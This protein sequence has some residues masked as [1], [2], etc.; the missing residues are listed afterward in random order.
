[1]TATPT[2][3]SLHTFYQRVRSRS[4][5]LIAPLSGEDC[6]LQS[7][8]DASPQKWHLAHTSWFWETFVLMPGLPG[9][10]PFDPAFAYLF[11]S[12]YNTVGEQYPR[13]LRGLLSRPDLNTVL[14]YREHVDAGMAR[15]FAGNP[16]AVADKQALIR[17]GLNHEQQHQ[18][19]QLTDVKHLLSLNPLA[20]AYGEAL[21]RP[22]VAHASLDWQ[23]LGGHAAAI[24]HEDGGFAFDNEM[25]AHTQWLAPY[26]IANR[27]VTNGEYLRF[28][29]AGGYR[30]PEFWLA[31]G[32]DHV[33]A[34][35]WAA[36]I[37]WRQ[38]DGQWLRF[39]LDG[40][41]PLA[42]DEPVA[43]LSLY[44]A[45]AYARFAGARLPTEFEWE[46]AA[47]HAGARASGL[48]D[49]AWQWTSSS[50]AAYPGFEPSAGAIGEYNGKFMVNQ[51]VLRGGS[52]LTPTGHTRFTYR[53][54]FPAATRWQ[55]TGVRLARSVR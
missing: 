31:E 8:P 47:R 10:R 3:D 15:W 24:G 2:T 40:E 35:G 39:G 52:R 50:Y 7:M 54:F 53:N 55:M 12:Y 25:P 34:Q 42:A 28:V 14:A 19:L 22:S 41:T 38:R 36:P 1:M 51:Y 37:Y 18:E 13:P 43:H 27:L 26:E 33:C 32:Y 30:R 9:F 48:L 23:A 46:H 11:N 44:E 20:P 6:A 17:L 16:G 45:D 4:L 21:D 29:E 5:T 49:T